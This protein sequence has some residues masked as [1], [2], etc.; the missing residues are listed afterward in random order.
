MRVL[1][2]KCEPTAYEDLETLFLN[3]MGAPIAELFD[4]LSP[5]PIG[6]AS[7]AQVH[8]GYHRASGKQVAV[9]V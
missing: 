8:V 4:D 2:D 9:K 3:D 1:Q 7:L 5:V 6:V